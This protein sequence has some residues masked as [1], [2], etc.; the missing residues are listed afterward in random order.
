IPESA[1]D[2]AVR[3]VLATKVR[4]GLFDDP[5]RGASSE[6]ER[7]LILA[8]KHRAL[9]REIGQEAIV[10]LKNDG[11]LLP[12]DKAAPTIAVIGPLANS[13]A[14]PLGPWH[15]LG[16]PADVVS[17]LDGIRAA[18]S[19]TTTVLHAPGAG[20]TDSSTAGFAEA[21]DLASQADAVIAVL[22]ERQDMSGEAASR[23]DIGLPG[24]QQE[25]LEALHATGVPVVLVLMNG[26]PLAI[27]WAAEHVPAIL[28][29]WF[30]GVEMGPALADV[31]FGDANPSGKLPVTFPRML[32]QVPIYYNHKNT[33][34]PPAEDKY[35]SKYLDVPVTPLF[36]FGHGLSYTE[37][38][39]GDLSL[40]SDQLAPTDSLIVSVAVTNTGDRDGAEVVQLYLQ[41]EVASVTR[42]VK[43]LRGFQRINLAPGD[44]KTI[45]F[46]VTPEDLGFYDLQMRRVIEPGYF[47][48]LV[49]GSSEDV[50]ETRFEVTGFRV[51]EEAPA[52]R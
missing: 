49:G 28:E 41:D 36:P 35:T 14:D 52:D 2:L 10:L 23:A 1:V 6:R 26:R 32:G 51:L 13:Q 40:S 27:P 5:Y 33:G 29:A 16:N 47:R 34:R 17:V 43:E 18:V 20:V 12:L 37:F 4:L 9:A 8:D 19:P 50:I 3:H 24:V 42:P 15:A 46:V 21:V 45:E 39:Y 48:A 22:G 30:L 44:S 25:L 38:E 31:L 7:R 11:N